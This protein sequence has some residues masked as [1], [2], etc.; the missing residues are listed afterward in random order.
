MEDGPT[1]DLFILT[2]P[3]SRS[4]RCPYNHRLSRRIQ[5]CR[6]P[7]SPSLS[8]LVRS[9]SLK[10]E[11]DPEGPRVFG[12]GLRGTPAKCPNRKGPRGPSAPSERGPS[13][14]PSSPP[15]PDGSTTWGFRESR[16][17]DRIRPG[18]EREGRPASSRPGRGGA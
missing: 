3:L 1:R 8:V 17:R 14:R 15:L 5:E 11:E 18:R 7:S 16:A 6:P 12:Q 9:L 4:S 10:R 2:C 13:C